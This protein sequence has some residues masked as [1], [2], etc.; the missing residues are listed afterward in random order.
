MKCKNCRFHYY[1]RNKSWCDYHED[2]VIEDAGCAFGEFPEDY[3]DPVDPMRTA[4]DAVVGERCRQI[5]IWGS[6][7]DASLFEFMSILGEEYGELCEAVNETCFK[8]PKH[9]ERGGL[10]NCYK[11]ACH[12]AAVAVKLMERIEMMR[13]VEH[14]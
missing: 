6:Q 2:Y 11:E 5:E 8:K 14:D 13:E 12:V 9:P 7:N 3:E 4:I 1:F 10:D